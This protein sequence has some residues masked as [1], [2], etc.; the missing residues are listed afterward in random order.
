[1]RLAAKLHNTT[2]NIL[3]IDGGGIR[4]LIPARIVEEL[5]RRIGTK[6]ARVFDLIVGTATGALVASALATPVADGR[7]R[8]YERT[9]RRSSPFQS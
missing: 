1:M 8:P 6:P 2:V 9:I 7:L 3:S 4:G 5:E